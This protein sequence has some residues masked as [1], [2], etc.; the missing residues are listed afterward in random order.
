MSD[1]YRIKF[2]DY[3]QMMPLVDTDSGCDGGGGGEGGGG[4][5]VEQESALPIQA[6]VLP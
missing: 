4:D 5:P 1:K 6:P 2:T 3:P